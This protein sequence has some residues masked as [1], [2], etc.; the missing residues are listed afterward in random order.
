MRIS[1]ATI[2]FGFLLSAAFA[3]ACWWT[4][5]VGLGLFFGSVAVV[6]TLAGPLSLAGNDK[7][8]RTLSWAAAV[9]GAGTV[10]LVAAAVSVV[11][12]GQWLSCYLV[13]CAFAVAL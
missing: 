9:D 6:A 12:F 3:A 7:W 2:A 11:T 13:L 5:G 10:L 8:N 4:A 1:W